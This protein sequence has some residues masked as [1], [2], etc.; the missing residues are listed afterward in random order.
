MSEEKLTRL[1]EL[2][3]IAADH[4]GVLHPEDVVEFAKNPATVL[5]KAF[6][7]DDE[8]AGHRYRL[9]QAR[10]IIR[11]TVTTLHP[12]GEEKRVR[13]F[14]SLKDDRKKDHNGGYKETSRLIKTA[15]G[16]K[17]ILRTA[18][19]ELKIFREKYDYLSELAGIFQAIEVLE[20]SLKGRN[21]R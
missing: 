2:R 4:D 21:R 12:E 1:E 9:E 19:A 15:D 6:Q 5:H 10:H 18:M 20:S 11:V 7:W 3:Q 17:A 16:R 13:A 8:K 14:I